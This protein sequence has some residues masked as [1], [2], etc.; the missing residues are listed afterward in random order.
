MASIHVGM[1]LGLSEI[2]VSELERSERLE[3]VLFEAKP[4]LDI[5]SEWSAGSADFASA[6]ISCFFWIKPEEENK[7][8]RRPSTPPR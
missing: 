2:G 3:N 6:L 5:F 8:A 4:S 1:S 7:L